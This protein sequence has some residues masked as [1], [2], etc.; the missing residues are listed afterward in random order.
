MN[1]YLQEVKVESPS[2]GSST[3]ASSESISAS[4]MPVKTKVRV[5]IGAGGVGKTTTS[6]AMA[7]SAALQGQRVLVLTVDPSLR[8]KTLLNLDK[9]GEI[10]EVYTGHLWATIIDHKKVFEDFVERAAQKSE[11]AK[12]LLNNHL[13]QQLTTNLVGSQ[14]FSSLEALY[15]HYESGEYDLILLDTPPSEH[16]LNFL[17]APQKLAQLFSNSVVK[18]FAEVQEAKSLWAKLL[19]TGTQQI[20]TV[21]KSLTGSQFIDELQDFFL[22]I[23]KW[24]HKLESR[25]LGVHRLLTGPQTQFTLVTALDSAKLEEALYLFRE[26]RKGG[27]KLDSVV[28]NRAQTAWLE[29]FVVPESCS[30]GLK[31]YLELRLSEDQKKD[32]ELGVFTQKLRGELEF[33]KVPDFAN[34]DPQLL[35]PQF[36]A[37]RYD[38]LFNKKW[39]LGLLFILGLGSGLLKPT[40]S[41]A[42]VSERA[43]EGDS[44]KAKAKVIQKKTAKAQKC[45]E[46]RRAVEELRYKNS[47]EAALQLLKLSDCYEKNGD[48]EK[49]TYALED[50]H[51]LRPTDE[52]AL[53][54]AKIYIRRGRSDLAEVWTEQTAN[55][56]DLI[57]DLRVRK[58]RLMELGRNAIDTNLN[59]DQLVSRLE[60]FQKFYLQ[61]EPDVSIPELVEKYEKTWGKVKTQGRDIAEAQSKRLLV[62]IGE[63]QKYQSEVPEKIKKIESEIEDYLTKKASPSETEKENP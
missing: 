55:L 15:T 14:D 17:S 42:E 18:W 27:Y 31:N 46:E 34:G 61:A 13:Y 63:I 26:L 19:Q 5:V 12:K 40:F 60:K 39:V 25:T 33:V 29:H 9:A 21:L 58:N 1:L 56:V 62:A 32:Q 38:L 54:L 22:S 43:K 41:Y 44:G 16:A 50:S 10:K 23:E 45:V 7:W 2:N 3:S 47:K 11:S 48:L 36:L 49:A 35:N 30:D 51:R 28:V 4:K 20:Y 6:V 24:Q 37:P 52:S 53:R 59:P 8:L 57:S